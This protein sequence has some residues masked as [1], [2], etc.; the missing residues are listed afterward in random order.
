VYDDF[1]DGRSSR[2]T[3][4]IYLNDDFNGGCTTF[5]TPSRVEHGVLDAR[6]V[7]PRQCAALVFPHG[8]TIGALLHEGSP[9]EQGAKYVVRT[10][11]LYT[12]A[13]EDAS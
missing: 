3:F 13:V 8:D 6:G 12:D 1:N 11:I 9:V 4:L 7:R 2:L 10:D 5:F